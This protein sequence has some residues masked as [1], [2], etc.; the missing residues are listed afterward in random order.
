MT[1]AQDAQHPEQDKG[2]APA[3]QHAED[4]VTHEGVSFRPVLW[5]MHPSTNVASTM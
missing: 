2:A 1:Q 5:L 3:D 4:H